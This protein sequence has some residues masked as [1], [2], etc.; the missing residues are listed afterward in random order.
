MIVIA[1]R[2]RWYIE[3]F[4]KQIKMFLGLEDVAAKHFKSVISHIH[5]VYCAYILL[6][7]PPPGALEQTDSFAEKQRMIKEIF[8]TKEKSRIAQLLTQFDGPRRY[9][10]ELQRSMTVC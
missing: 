10:A 4:H 2:L 9:K 8:D 7:R 5:W 1:Y 6:T 3:I